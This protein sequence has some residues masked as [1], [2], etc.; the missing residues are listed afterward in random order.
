MLNKIYD[1]HELRTAFLIW[2][3]TLNEL[4]TAYIHGYLSNT[5]FISRL[6]CMGFLSH[7]IPLEMEYVSGEIANLKA[8]SEISITPT[9]ISVDNPA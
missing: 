5:A 4:R 6:E 1:N 2:R 7:E 8:A 9:E 3:K